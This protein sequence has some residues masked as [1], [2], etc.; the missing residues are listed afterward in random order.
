MQQRTCPVCGKNF[1]PRTWNHTYCTGY[2]GQCSRK[3]SNERYRAS[4]EYANY[5][6]CRRVFARVRGR[7]QQVYCSDACHHT[8]K[9]ERYAGPTVARAVGPPEV[10]R[11]EVARY[12]KVLRADPCAYCGE[13]PANGID[14]IDCLVTDRKDIENMT[15][16]CKRCNELKSTVPLLPALIWIPITR[17][18]HELRR[19]LYS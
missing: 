9:A 2:R 17:R 13:R 3:V 11:R 1:T 10:G 12:R 19:L 16:C 7:K 5:K 15:G 14:H 18:Y 4:K 6:H 8:A